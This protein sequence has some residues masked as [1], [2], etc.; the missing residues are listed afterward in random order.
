M[1]DVL[2]TPAFLTP[3]QQAQQDFEASVSEDDLGRDTF[4]TLLTTQL[5]NQNPLD[6]MDNQEFVAQLAQFSSVEGIKGMQESLEDMS[7]SNTSNARQDQLLAGANLV[8]KVAQV[9]D[10]KGGEGYPVTGLLSLDTQAD[11][12]SIDVRNAATGELVKSFDISVGDLDGIPAGM[13]FFAWDGNSEG[14]APAPAGIYNMQATA[15]RDGERALTAVSAVEQ[16]LAATW[17]PMGNEVSLELASGSSVQLSSVEA[18]L[19]PNIFAT[20]SGGNDN[21]DNE[22]I[23]E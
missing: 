8:G 22:P 18:F 15:V 2:S 6:P 19:D 3:E 7:V 23:V 5:T 13:N 12:V 11:S 14:G 16:I 20:P 21:G 4:L 1:L 9:S 17:D 10:F